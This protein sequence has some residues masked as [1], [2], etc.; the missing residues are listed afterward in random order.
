MREAV[1]RGKV[2]HEHAASSV[3]GGAGWREEEGTSDKK[4]G[5]SPPPVEEAEESTCSPFDP[6]L[7]NH[8]ECQPPGAESLVGAFSQKKAA[9]TVGPCSV[10]LPEGSR[11]EPLRCATAG[12][13]GCQ[14]DGDP[15]HLPQENPLQPKLEASAPL[16]LPLPLPLPHHPGSQEP[17]GVPDTTGVEE[18]GNTKCEGGLEGRRDP[19]PSPPAVAAPPRITGTPTLQGSCGAGASPGDREARGTH[20]SSLESVPAFFVGGKILAQAGQTYWGVAADGGA[21][22]AYL[23]ECSLYCADK[24]C[25]SQFSEALSG[26]GGGSGGTVEVKEGCEQV[27]PGGGEASTAMQGGG[28]ALLSGGKEQDQEEEQGPG[29]GW[30][31]RQVQGRRQGQGKGHV[32]GEGKAQ[33]Q[34]VEETKGVHASDLPS[35]ADGTDSQSP[36]AVNH[37]VAVV[38][39]GGSPPAGTCITPKVGTSSGVSSEVGSVQVGFSTALVAGSARAP[40]PGAMPCLQGEG[41]T[42]GSEIELTS[43]SPS[44][45][46]GRQ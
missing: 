33:D 35:M 38:V 1:A 43:K 36:S 15:S 5:S 39:R 20:H 4:A 9:N 21:G 16:P 14:D 34:V 12:D 42:C 41:E 13:L 37:G 23:R 32:Q 26:E 6:Q 30:E 27:V 11:S 3:D 8:L 19:N 40:D 25:P 24:P 2:V 10:H 7:P 44:F 22:K 29:Q 18:A 17:K 28:R 45:S 46:N 31:H